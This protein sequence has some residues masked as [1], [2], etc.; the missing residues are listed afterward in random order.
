MPGPTDDLPPSHETPAAGASS[1]APTTPLPATEATDPATTGASGASGGSG[2]GTDGPADDRRNLWLIGL[3][4][5]VVGLAIGVVLVLVLRDNGS[6]GT[7]TTTTSSTSSTSTSSSSSTETTSTSRSTTTRSPTTTAA[8]TTTVSTAPTIVSFVVPL[9]ANCSG[10]PATVSITISWKTTNT[11]KV[12]ISIDGPGIFQTYPG[13][14]G[15]DSFPFAC[16]NSSNTY[17]LTGHGSDGTT[18]SRTTT[19]AKA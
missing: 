3:I 15:S 16:S 13:S 14:S 9:T 10:N 18:V 8:P 5:F 2:G 11:T 4:I 17:T 6:K 19:V 1:D 7:N 12:D